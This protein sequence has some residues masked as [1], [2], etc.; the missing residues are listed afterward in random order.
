MTRKY[1]FQFLGIWMVVLILLICMLDLSIYNS[2]T[3]L[4][5]TPIAHS[6]DALTR[7]AY[8]K[9]FAVV[10]IV[11][12]STVLVSAMASLALFSGHRI[13]GP[14]LALKRTMGEIRDGN[15]DA[16]LHFRDYDKM[17]DVEAAFNE[18]MD[19]LQDEIRTSKNEAELELVV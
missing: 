5:A 3:Q 15:F 11:L 10:N 18:M 1:R 8:Q 14:Y 17:E 19:V 9:W 12:L 7:L 2:Y 4:W 13:G 16:R 6:A